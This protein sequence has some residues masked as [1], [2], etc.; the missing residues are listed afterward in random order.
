MHRT[1]LS[2]MLF[3]LLLATASL[4]AVAQQCP[5]NFDAVSP[6]LLPAGWTSALADGGSGWTTTNASADTAPNA[7]FAAN[8][9][10]FGLSELTGPT[11]TPTAGTMIMAFRNN[12][13][14]EASYDGGVLEIRIGAGAFTDFVTAGGSFITGGYNSTIS[15]SFNN[16]LG[17]RQAWSGNSNG[18]ID[19]ALQLPPAALGQPTTLK[20]RLGTDTSVGSTGW[21]IDSIRCGY[22]PPVADWV[23]VA[24][25][26]IPILDQAT[27]VQNGA[28]Y[29]FTGVTAG[30]L[31]PN[32]YKFDGTA[33]TAIAPH[34]AMVEGPVAVSDGTY[35]Y[36]LGGTDNNG[37]PVNTMYRYSPATN[38]YQAMAP[39]TTAVWATAAAVVNGKIVKVAGYNSGGA[40]AATEI[41]NIALGTWSAG[42]DLPFALGFHSAFAHNGFVYVVG[43]VDAASNTSTKTWR[44]DPVLNVWDDAVVT[45]LPVSRWGAATIE[46]PTGVLLAG[47][48]VG[49]TSSSNLSA[50]AIAWDGPTNTWQTFPAMLAARARMTGGMLQGT[51]T[52]IGGRDS[53]GGFNG[54]QLVQVYGGSGDTIFADGFEN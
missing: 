28:L 10:A 27:A 41:Y 40:T 43:G 20:W 51:P 54:T 4:S 21:Y 1:T 32:T 33:W 19:T 49:G 13:A 38:S 22:T 30:V 24:D 26:P 5:E 14:T 44:Y 9:A 29:S 2:S 34:P 52:V 16:P 17:G 11:F 53:A 3:G 42:A 23:A 7:A 35:I 15:T 47:G 31:T 6:P 48:Y 45:D 12:Y 46:T 39:F 50:T 8:V 25:Y 37:N 18:F 36:I